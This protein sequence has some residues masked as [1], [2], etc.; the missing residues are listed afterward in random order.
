VDFLEN[1][2]NLTHAVRVPDLSWS[3]EQKLASTWLGACSDSVTLTPGRSSAS[4]RMRGIT[5]TKVLKT[6]C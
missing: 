2:L 1:R 6:K 3:S 4:C 5:P